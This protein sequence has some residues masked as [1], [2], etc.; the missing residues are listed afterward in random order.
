MPTRVQLSPDGKKLMLSIGEPLA[1]LWIYDLARNTKTRLTYGNEGYSFASW[2]PD[3]SQIGG[4]GVL[5]GRA[6]M[7]K[8]SHGAGEEKQLLF[9]DPAKG[10]QQ[11]LCDWSADGRY[12]IYRAGTSSVGTGL[13][14]WILPLFGDQAVSLYHGARRPVPC[15]VFSRWTVGRL[16]VK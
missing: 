6:I 4:G 11:V 15:P 7:S 3:G 1:A 10:L 16:C 14:L 12:L 13:D 9:L 2:S 8:A 5:T